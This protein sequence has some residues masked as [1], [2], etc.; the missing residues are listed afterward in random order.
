MRLTAIGLGPGDPELVT[1]KGLRAIQAAD[2]VFVPRSRDGETSL[3]LR[4]AEPWIDRGR[5]RIVEL[6][7]PM[8]RNADELMPAWAAAAEVIVTTL[9]P[10]ERG[11]YLLLGD[12]LLY[13]TFT[14]IWRALTSRA[15]EISI[16]IIPGVTSFAAAA[17]ATQTVLSTTD[18]HVAIIPA[19]RATTIEKLRRLLAEC[20]TLIVIKVGSVLPQ[21]L[22]A[23]DELGLLDTT[24]YAER[25][26]MPEQR[27]VRDVR[28]LQGQPQP[29]LSLLIVRRRRNRNES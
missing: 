23:L 20:D 19:S 3:A 2:A 1:V 22:A 18:E 9:G 17:A 27:I 4:I 14:Y 6:P 25:V 29:Y 12:P 10:A 13:G 7:L 26:G 11:V 16:E 5:Q 24:I 15:A 8:T 21:V 28:A